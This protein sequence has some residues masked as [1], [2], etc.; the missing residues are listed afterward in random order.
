MNTLIKPMNDKFQARSKNTY[1]LVSNRFL[2]VIISSLFLMACGGGSGSD[3]NASTDPDRDQNMPEMITDSNRGGFQSIEGR[4]TNSKE[5]I[6]AVINTVGTQDFT[7][8]YTVTT[9]KIEYMTVDSSNELLKVSGL[10]AIP[11]KTTPSP[12]ISY[13]HATTFS[14][15]EAPSEQFALGEKS[16]EIALASLGYIVFSPDYIGFGS[17]LGKDHPYL[18]KQ[19]SAAVVTDMLKAAKAWIDFKKIKTNGQLF[20]TGYS[21]G[22][23]V[24]MAA[25]QE[26][27]NH[28]QEGMNVVT[29]VMGAGPYNLNL[30]LTELVEKKLGFTLPQMN[31]P[32]VLSGPVINAIESVFIPGNADVGYESLFLNRFLASDHQDDVHNWKPSMPI[33]LFHGD[34]DKIVPISSSESTVDTMLALGADVELV[35]CT[36]IPAGHKDCVPHYIS[37]VVDTF[38]AL[39]RQ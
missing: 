15:S 18:Q 16:I 19:P 28:P 27:Q 3:S 2:F 1:F 34:D 20:M 25:L 13:Q 9:Y 11:E 7:A 29:A 17:S 6:Q 12:I 31:I 10:I 33:I 37:L 8:E 30:T 39:K 24:T 32:A 4:T 22:A 38:E 26:Y 23:Y 21:Q 36:A 14:S 5:A 35:R